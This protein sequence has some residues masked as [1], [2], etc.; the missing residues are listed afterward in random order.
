MHIEKV[1]VKLNRP[2]LEQGHNKGKRKKMLSRAEL[3]CK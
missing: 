3:K 2:N 1:I